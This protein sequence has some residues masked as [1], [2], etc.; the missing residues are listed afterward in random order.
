[1]IRPVVRRNIGK[2][3]VA[4]LLVMLVGTR[5]PIL[6]RGACLNSQ[7]ARLTDLFLAERVSPSRP[8]DA[9]ACSNT[10]LSAEIAVLT[11]LAQG[12][13]WQAERLFQQLSL[14]R[15]SYPRSRFWTN[16]LLRAG[17]LLDNTAV[18][19]T[20]Y[21]LVV[22]TA[23]WDPQ[24][25]Y[26][27]GKYCEA[28]KH[29]NEAAEAYRQGIQIG[30]PD[31]AYGYL[32]LG[33]LLYRFT[34]SADALEALKKS[35]TLETT[36][37]V[38]PYWASA[39]LYF[40]MA[41]IYRQNSDFDQALKYYTR[42]ISMSESVG[43]PVYAAHLGIGDVW[44]AKG[45]RERARASY[46]DALNTSDS[47][48]NRSA[49]YKKLGAWYLQQGDRDQAVQTYRKAIEFNPQDPWGYCDLGLVYEQG[50]AVDMAVR[51]YQQALAVDPNLTW[52]QQALDR[53]DTQHRTGK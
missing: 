46:E 5:I 23:P 49:V 30:S 50:T 2:M 15:T 22:Q 40:Y 36:H 38:L 53:L 10:R 17:D 12:N 39:M 7:A 43:W 19:E 16:R 4:S 8:T 29:V 24:V 3:L 52:A 44:L 25:W 28:H 21:R 45:Q 32:L 35:E 42:V 34:N 33:G 48:V 14:S 26:A 27:L 20:A 1:M 13:S 31:A 41:E 6:V 37:P 18:A 9:N 51:L 11:A 47:D